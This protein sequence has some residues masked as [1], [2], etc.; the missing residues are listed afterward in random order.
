MSGTILYTPATGADWATAWEQAEYTRKGKHG[1]GLTNMDRTGLPAIGSGSWAEVAG[2][3]YKWVS[4][5][6]IS[7]SPTAGLINYIT[8]VPSGSGDTAIVTATWSTTAPT[9]SD[10]YQGW[11]NGTTRYL[12]L[13]FYTGSEYIEKQIIEPVRSPYTQYNLYSHKYNYDRTRIVGFTEDFMQDDAGTMGP[14]VGAA[15]AGGASTYN[16]GAA[17]HPGMVLLTNAGG[18]NSGYRYNTEDDSIVITGGEIFEVI[19]NLPY[20]TNTN[21]RLG[22]HDTLSISAPTDGIYIYS[23]GTTL[24]GRTYNNSALSITGSTYTISASTWYRELIILNSDAT[25][26]DFNL[27][28]E[29][30]AL[31]WHDY[32]TTNI[33]VTRT[34]GVVLGIWN[35]DGTTRSMINLDWVSFRCDR[36]LTR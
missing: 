25:R 19:F 7:G 3:I 22:L 27:Y 32:L 8:L 36:I 35:S 20:P 31:L 13:C 5:E 18:A 23:T 24:D 30:G 14:L 28:S 21:M 4:E 15:I 17:N 11:Y 34:V 29:A 12:A 9:W 26:A 33:P 1:I 16:G 10:A 6:A 2:S